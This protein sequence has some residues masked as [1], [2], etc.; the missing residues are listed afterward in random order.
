VQD[1]TAFVVGLVAVAAADSLQR[2]DHPVAA[3]G[4]GIRDSQPRN[5]SIAGHQVET[6]RTADME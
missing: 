3:F 6:V 5:A 1:D 2:L 4:S